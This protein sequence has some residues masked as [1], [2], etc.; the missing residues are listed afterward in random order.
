[1]RFFSWK[2][3]FFTKKEKCPFSLFICL[4]S[5]WK[6]E[7]TIPPAFP[8]QPATSADEWRTFFSLSLAKAMTATRASGRSK[9]GTPAGGRGKGPDSTPSDS[10][11]ERA[12]GGRQQAGGPEGPTR[13]PARAIAKGG[14]QQ[15]ATAKAGVQPP[16]RYKTKR[17]SSDR[18]RQ[19]A[20]SERSE[21]C[22]RFCFASEASGYL[23]KKR[24]REERAQRDIFL[25]RFLRFTREAERERS[26]RSGPFSFFF[27]SA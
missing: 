16:E 3:L 18:E 1:V 8:P 19:R 17:G 9:G 10:G 15:A 24:K 7:Q 4:L 2:L 13:P 14:R 6:R 12:K 5:F 25:K 27:F 11:R 20:V 22:W 21:R 23:T 26:E